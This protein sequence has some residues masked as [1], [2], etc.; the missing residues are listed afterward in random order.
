[1]TQER[2]KNNMRKRHQKGSLRKEGGGWVAQWWEGGRRRKK[3]L[4]STN[5]ADAELDLLAILAPINSNEGLTLPSIPLGEFVFG[6]YLPFYR[7]K[8]KRSTARSNEERI[9]FHV[10]SPYT[11]RAL[12]SFTREEFQAFLDR[13]GKE[14]YSY[15]VVHHLRWDLKQIFDMAVA[16]GYVTRNPASLLFPPRDCPR[17]SARIMTVKEV[18]RMLAAL[19]TREQLIAALA[20]IAG[21]RPGEIFGLTWER[22]TAGYVDVRQR[23]YRGEVDSPKSFHSVRRAALSDGLLTMIGA[24]REL[25]PDTGPGA[26]VFS[27]ET[28]V[29]PLSRD[30]CWHRNFL[31]RLRPVGLAWANFLVMRRTHS[32]LMKELDVDPKVRAEQMGHTV[33]VNENVYTKTSVAK[34][35]QAVNQLESML[36][37]VLAD[38]GLIQ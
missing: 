7:R 30:N 36:R 31:P 24:W 29:T 34:R 26:W 32:C 8:W 2:R 18:Q 19:D 1:M 22:L 10:L 3:R 6:T 25:S 28:L 12:S 21:L 4:G 5:K 27:S 33:D 14:G 15:S 35:R 38:P 16:E 13:K 17:P 37:V 23:V 9:R 20:I 11:K